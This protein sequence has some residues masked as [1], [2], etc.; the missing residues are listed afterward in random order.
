VTVSEDG[1]KAFIDLT[2]GQGQMQASADL[3][4]DPSFFD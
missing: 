4:N 2:V 3:V 1:K